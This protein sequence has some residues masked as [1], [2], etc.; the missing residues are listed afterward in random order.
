MGQQLAKSSE[1]E[2]GMVLF[3]ELVAPARVL[4]VEEPH[5]TNRDGPGAS[6]LS[7]ADLST[8]GE[9]D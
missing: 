9:I 7:R 2:G 1:A 5:S 3:G 6:T 4:L 8:R